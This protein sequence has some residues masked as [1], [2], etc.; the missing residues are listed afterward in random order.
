VELFCDNW[1]DKKVVDR[2]RSK[3]TMA[4]FWRLLDSFYNRPAEL[5]QDL[6]TEISAFKKI[7]YYN[8]ERLLEYYV[9]LRTISYSRHWSEQ[10]NNTC[11]SL[12]PAPHPFHLGGW[13]LL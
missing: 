10:Q 7:Q 8:Y 5:A 1:L 11:C 13:R 2:R 6:L 4:E 12:M 9:L 3:E